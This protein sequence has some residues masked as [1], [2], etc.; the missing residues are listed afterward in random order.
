MDNICLVCR[1]KHYTVANS[2]EQTASVVEGIHSHILTTT[3]VE[4]LAIFGHG[5][6]SYRSVQSIYIGNQVDIVWRSLLYVTHS[7]L[8]VTQS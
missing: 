3:Y 4:V 1:Y 7:W 5:V 2:A 8:P 6:Y